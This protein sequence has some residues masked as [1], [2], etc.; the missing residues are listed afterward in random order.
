MGEL[1]TVGRGEG[2]GDALAL[3]DPRTIQIMDL[4]F[5]VQ[6]KLR[7]PFF[8][9]APNKLHLD[10]MTGGV[11]DACSVKTKVPLMSEPDRS[12]PIN[13]LLLIS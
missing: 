4:P 6:I 7:L 8:A 2:E 13:L 1:L 10:P 11:A 9:T 5:L 3:D 12:T